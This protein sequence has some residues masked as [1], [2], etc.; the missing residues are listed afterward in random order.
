MLSRSLQAEKSLAPQKEKPA[1][2]TTRRARL[3]AQL[4]AQRRRS[5]RS[6]ATLK[7]LEDTSQMLKSFWQQ[8]SQQ[9]GNFELVDDS[10]DSDDEDE[11]TDSDDEEEKF[12]EFADTVFETA[13]M[14]QQSNPRNI[15]KQPDSSGL[16]FRGS[17]LISQQL[18]CCPAVCS[19][20]CKRCIF[21]I[22]VVHKDVVCWMLQVSCTDPASCCFGF[23]CAALPGLALS[24]S[25]QRA[26]MWVA[27][28]LL[29]ALLAFSVL[30]CL[31]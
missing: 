28:T 25:M 23:S 13:L 21:C 30:L 8:A 3:Q 20:C 1:A 5:K 10:D 26:Y 11:E 31:V 9:R 12:Q 7:A 27:Q 24:S 19:D 16:L 15:I 2:P 6:K 17:F 18:L 22:P 4:E 29:P 14:M